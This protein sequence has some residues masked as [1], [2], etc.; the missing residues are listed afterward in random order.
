MIPR[1]PAM[2]RDQASGREFRFQ[3][4]KRRRS[5]LAVQPAVR[6]APTGSEPESFPASLRRSRAAMPAPAGH[7][8]TAAAT[9]VRAGARAGSVGPKYAS[10]RLRAV[11]RE[12]CPEEQP[13][14][15]DAAR[16]LPREGIS[17]AQAV[18]SAEWIFPPADLRRPDRFRGWVRERHSQQRPAANWRNLTAYPSVLP[19]EKL[20][21]RHRPE[22]APEAVAAAIRPPRLE[23]DTGDPV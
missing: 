2:A 23:A 10:E 15:W 3:S 5:V 13:A 4:W 9:G 18:L 7:S 1:W 12:I 21:V 19:Q 17:S 16:R 22:E 6:A 20:R 14:A 8:A 11:R